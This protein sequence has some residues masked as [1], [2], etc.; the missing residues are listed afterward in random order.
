[1]LVWI[2]LE[3]YAE[4]G[5]EEGYA[6]EGYNEYAEEGYAEEGY[7]EG[8]EEAYAE[9]GYGEEYYAEEGNV[10]D[11][12]LESEHLQAICLNTSVYFRGGLIFSF[13]FLV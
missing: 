2:L 1:M 8:Y 7:A 11:V 13:F 4:E 5:Y 10:Y 9:E 12:L 3:A 6:E